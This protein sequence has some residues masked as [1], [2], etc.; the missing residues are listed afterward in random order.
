MANEEDAQL[1]KLVVAF[2]SAILFLSNVSNQSVLG[3]MDKGYCLLQLTIQLNGEPY[4]SE[5]I[6]CSKRTNLIPEKIYNLDKFGNPT[7]P[8]DNFVID[9]AKFIDLSSSTI[10]PIFNENNF[11]FEVSHEQYVE[12][13]LEIEYEIAINRNVIGKHTLDISRALH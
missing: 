5:Q 3:V 4:C 2:D 11:I 9:P 10:M 13:A 6:V 12:G 8:I 1:V 7:E